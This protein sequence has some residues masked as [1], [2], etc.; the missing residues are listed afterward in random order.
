MSAVGGDDD[1]GRIG[2]REVVS[3]NLYLLGLVGYLH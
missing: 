3:V 1:V 2:T